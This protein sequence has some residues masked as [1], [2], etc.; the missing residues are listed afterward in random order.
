MT[1]V[2]IAGTSFLVEHLRVRLNL[3]LLIVIPTLFVLVSADVLEEF[4]DALGGSLVGP[5]ASALGAGWAAAF[6]AGTLSFFQVA[7]SREADR[8]L[9]LAGLGVPAVATARMSAAIVLGGIVSLAAFVTLWG[10]SAPEHPAH[11]LAAILAFALI[12]I[13][14]GAL[15]GSFVSDELQGA[16]AVAMVFLVDTFSG[17]GMTANDGI[18][19]AMPSRAAAEVLLDAGSGTSSGAGE[20]VAMS[21]SAAGALALAFLAFWLS[22]RPRSS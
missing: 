17:P 14:I 11:A 7:S 12:Y 13:G 15:I 18:A 16:L 20:W 21:L 3:V 10:R 19:Q 5:A 8:R 1:G 2:A 6:L 22:A 9:S 4:A